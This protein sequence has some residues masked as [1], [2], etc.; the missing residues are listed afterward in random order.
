[1]GWAL[2]ID[3]GTSRTTAALAENDTINQLLID[4]DRYMPSLVCLDE[5]HL[6]TGRTAF[7]LAMA[8][9]ECAER[10]PKRAVL[11][12]DELL[13]DGRPFRVVQLIAAALSTVAKKAVQRAGSPPDR[14]VLTHPVQREHEYLRAL[15]EAAELAGLPTPEFVP[16]PVAAALW[17]ANESR[18][19]ELGDVIVVFDFGGGTLDT[20]VLRR[21]HNGYFLVGPPGGDALLGGED[22]DEQLHGLL[23]RTAREADPDAWEAI[24]KGETNPRNRRDRAQ[25]RQSAIDAKHDL[26][27]QLTTTVYL[28][29]FRKSFRITRQQL[30]QSMSDIMGR[31]LGTLTDTLDKSGT[32]PHQLAAVYLT[33]GSSRIPLV[34]DAVAERL[35]VNPQL[36]HDPKSVVVIG[37]A[38]WALH[39]PRVASN[40]SEALA[41]YQ[42]LLTEQTRD[43]GPDHPDT[44]TTRRRVGEYTGDAGDDSGAVALLTALLD[45]Q[46]RVLDPDD[47]IVLETRVLL[48][49]YTASTGRYRQA[50]DQLTSLI[51]DL[52]R[53]SGENH[54]DT[55]SVRFLWWAYKGMSGQ[56]EEAAAQL[57]HLHG[58]ISR[59]NGPD[60]SDTLAMELMRASVVSELD[61]DAALRLYEELLPRTIHA[62]GADHQWTLAIRNNIAVGTAD[63]AESL[64]LLEALLPDLVRVPGADAPI[65]LMAR[66]N[67]ATMTGRVGDWETAVDQFR[68]V[69]K[70]RERINGKYH[71]ETLVVRSLIAQSLYELG[72]KPEAVSLMRDVVR[73][74]DQHTDGSTEAVAIARQAL[75]DWTD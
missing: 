11:H 17:Y 39:P 5:D 29:G 43:L 49:G 16:E 40:A 56:P 48:A 66:H 55:L 26:S 65:T 67:I 23:D 35:G 71:P 20:A 2:V 31:A 19:A 28:P 38:H 72:R 74:Y 12:S 15:T 70:D 75:S 53:T 3:Y 30:D 61:E 22:V 7:S 37:A 46:R 62:M 32:A 36:H 9:P 4:D 44:L 68:A 54:P 21:T 6:V 1:M 52:T 60:H 34:H 47:M 63:P 57:L 33:G 27:D 14:L 73:D 51:D 24:F 41:G 42:K 10:V 69:L 58:E 59:V 13:L 50:L 8:M 18:T 25:T 45:D 64:R